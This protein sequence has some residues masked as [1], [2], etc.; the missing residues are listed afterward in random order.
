M[1][2]LTDSKVDDVYLSPFDRWLIQST[3]ENAKKNTE[4]KNKSKNGEH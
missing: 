4:N 1:K 2:T 3:V